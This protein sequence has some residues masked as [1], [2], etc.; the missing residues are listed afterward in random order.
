MAAD[1]LDL[2]AVAPITFSPG[3][4]AVRAIEEIPLP[5]T[6]VAPTGEETTEITGETTA[7]IGEEDTINHSLKDP[8][9]SELLQAVRLL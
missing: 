1:I 6:A 3:T 8:E 2:L 9:E 5:V 7:P 4:T